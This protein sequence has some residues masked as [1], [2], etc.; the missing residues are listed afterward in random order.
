MPRYAAIDIG[1][2]SVRMLAAETAPGRA[3]KILAAERQVTRLG[4]GVFLN[5]K[6]PPDAIELVCESLARMAKVF[7]QLDVVGVRAVAT[8]AVR[9]ASNQQEFLDRAAQVLGR[10]VEIISGQ[11]EARLIHLGVEATWPQPDKRVLIIDV[12]GG[13]AEIILGENGTF[14]EAFSKPLG[15]VRLT[16]VFLKSDPPLPL[17]LHRLNEYIEEKLAT[18]LRRIGAGPFDRVI[19]TSATAAAIVCAVNRVRRSR[20]DEADRLKASAAQIRKFYR[21]VCERDLAARRK[22][23]GIGPKRAELIVAGAA[24][25]LRALELFHQ[26]ALHYSAAGVRDGIIADLASRSVGRELSM[27]NGDQRRAVEQMARRYGVQVTHARKVA[28]LAR[29]LF[30]S[31]QSL[32]RLPPTLAKLLEAA[33]YL[34]DVGHYVSDTAHHKHSYYLVINSDLPGFTDTERQMIALLCRYH[35]RSMPVSRHSPFQTLDP[36]AQRAILLL[37]PLLRIADSL[38]RSHDQR[39]SDLQVQLRN[40]SVAIALESGQDTDLEVWAAERVADSFR[41]T[42]QLPLTLTKVRS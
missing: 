2:N 40:G 14:S 4:A 24:V 12:G 36:E 22:I 16:E 28:E 33:A 19:A 27:L 11:E 29:R 7:N 23:L 6:I 21:E 42:Y 8:S 3:T 9:D 13:S 38:D 34:H 26:P 10:P 18:P 25:F 30:E 35:R 41:E 5:G 39:V 31:L 32:H 20:R 1:S 15:A 17:E 37:T